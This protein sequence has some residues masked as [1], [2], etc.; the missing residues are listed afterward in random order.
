MH[1][2]FKT[3]YDTERNFELQIF[4]NSKLIELQIFLWCS[5]RGFQKDIAKKFGNKFAR[6]SLVI[7]NGNK[8]HE[9]V[10]QLCVFL[11]RHESNGN[12]QTK[13]QA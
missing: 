3:Q 1:L 10:I 11:L 9:N 5:I 2:D 13:E 12:F 8:Y 7:S 4:C 6:A